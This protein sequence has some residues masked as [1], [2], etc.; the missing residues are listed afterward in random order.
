MSFRRTILM[1]LALVVVAGGAEAGRRPPKRKRT[2]PAPALPPTAHR[3]AAPM[4]IRKIAPPTAAEIA[5]NRATAMAWYEQA[6]RDINADLHLVEGPNFLIFSAWP[7]G[8]DARLREVCE[9]MYTHLREK[10][11]MPRAQPVWAGKLPVFTFE[12]VEDFRRFC[13]LVG[14]AGMR[15][16]GGFTMQ[17]ADGFCYVA[18]NKVH[19]RTHF[20]GLLVHEGTHAFLARYHT[21]GFLPEWVNEGLAELMSAELVPSCAAG[22]RYVSATA[23]ALRRG[24]DVSGIFREVT[25][26]DFEYGVAQSLVRFLLARSGSDF[27]KFLKLLKIGMDP[28]EAL[29]KSYGLTGEQLQAE[30]KLASRQALRRTR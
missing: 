24:R 19:T 22:A 5:R 26:G 2:S 4:A 17:R 23:E 3:P 12:K 9:T 10:L 6:R 14:E 15:E 30:W 27:V 21:N 7:R 16:S 20:Y 1:G 25:L 29:E 28:S 11:A 18:L 13:G 8:A